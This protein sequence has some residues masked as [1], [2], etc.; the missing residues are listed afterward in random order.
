MR[1]TYKRKHWWWEETFGVNCLKTVS[2]F[3]HVELISQFLETFANF[4]FLYI[5]LA[6]KL[7]TEDFLFLL[8]SCCKAIFGNNYYKEIENWWL[9]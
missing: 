7:W 4:D 8:P 9:Q 2:I 3:E 1:L 6:Y 5:Y